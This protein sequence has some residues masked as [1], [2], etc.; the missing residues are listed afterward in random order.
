MNQKA[1]RVAQPEPSA[2]RT[3]TM[4]RYHFGRLML[5]TGDQERDAVVRQALQ[6]PFALPHREYH[7]QFTD[8]AELEAGGHP[9]QTGHLT[10]FRYSGNDE[11][12][13]VD[14][15]SI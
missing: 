12:V 7:C 6:T 3:I 14:A 10:Y 8:V 11:R 2:A 13:D 1:K 5:I 4:G 15:M 9:F